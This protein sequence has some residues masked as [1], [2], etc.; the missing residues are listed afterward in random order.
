MKYNFINKF[1][2]K[3]KQ[4]KF[5]SFRKRR[6]IED[7]V[8][9]ENFHYSGVFIRRWESG[10][11]V[12]NVDLFGSF[13]NTCLPKVWFS[14]NKLDEFRNVDSRNELFSFSSKINAFRP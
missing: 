14:C 13:S 5:A 10:E 3:S 2:F 7:R 8:N 11:A 4:L 6:K 12:T 9:L 1:I